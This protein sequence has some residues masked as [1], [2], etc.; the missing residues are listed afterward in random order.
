MRAVINEI[1]EGLV[2]LR[3]I[4]A[5]KVD[6]QALDIG[7]ALMVWEGRDGKGAEVFG[8]IDIE[9]SDV[10]CAVEEE[11]DGLRVLY[12]RSAPGR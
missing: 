9:G 7:D 5:L 6:D 1:R 4:F 10:W 2:P 12:V 3:I 11:W 8:E